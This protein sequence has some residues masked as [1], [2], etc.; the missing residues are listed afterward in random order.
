MRSA[1]P[2]ATKRQPPRLAPP[3]EAVAR[4]TVLPE[5]VMSAP[6]SMRRPPPSAVALTPCAT[7]LTSESVVLVRV[8]AA[9]AD[10]RTAPPRA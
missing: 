4:A 1:E 5:R 6:L 2:P 8:T 3:P 10:A 9:E 7:A